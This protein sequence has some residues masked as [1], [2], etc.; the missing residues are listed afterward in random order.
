MKEKVRI[1]IIGGSGLYQMDGVED[2]TT[3]AVD[4][5]FGKPSDELIIGSL[6]GEKIAFLARHKRG[7]CIMPTEINFRANIYALKSIGVEWIISISAVGSLREEFQPL[8]MVIPDQ[9]FDYTKH[10]ISTFFGEGMVAHVGMADP[11]C[12]TLSQI[13]L[14]TA[15]DAGC[16][17]H[18]G[19][20]YVCIEGPQFSTR[21]E[22]NAY[23]QLGFDIIGMTAMPE[24]KLAREAQICYATLAMVTD[25]DVWHESTGDVT[26]EMVIENLNKNV[27]N[28]KRIINN[29]ISRIPQERGGG[30]SGTCGCASA[31]KNAVITNPDIIPDETRKKLALLKEL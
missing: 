5:P 9:V 20:T 19:G 14:D 27:A 25:Y 18:K 4:T 28:A 31:L 11:F 8:D 15:T 3:M 29:I 12:P 21:A 7:H 26:V 17:V 30:I 2:I 23:R 22:S 6:N 10:R 24:A 1:G 13:L 16:C